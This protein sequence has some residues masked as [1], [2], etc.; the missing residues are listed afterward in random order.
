[1]TGPQGTQ[2]SPGVTGATGPQGATGPSYFNDVLLAC[3]DPVWVTNNYAATYTGNKLTRETWTNASTGNLI[4]SIDYTYTG[5]KLTQEVRKIYDST[6][7]IV[8]GEVT[9]VYTYTGNT[10]TSYT[11][12][13]NI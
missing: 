4:K 2:G 7:T 8:I 13:R 6:G 5:N 3:N 12:T 10:L 9:I 1:V 11:E